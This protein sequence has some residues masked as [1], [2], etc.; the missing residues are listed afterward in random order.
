ME[1][2]TPKH[3]ANGLPASPAGAEISKISIICSQGISGQG[4]CGQGEDDCESLARTSAESTKFASRSVK[5]EGLRRENIFRDS[6]AA[7]CAG[8]DAA[9][10]SRSGMRSPATREPSPKL[11]WERGLAR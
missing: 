6:M 5:R 8:E 7:P 1:G 10:I 4:S 9:R 2:L 11:S 3:S